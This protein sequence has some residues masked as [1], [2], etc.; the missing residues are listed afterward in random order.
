[1][2][3]FLSVAG[4]DRPKVEEVALALR[5]EGHEV[6]LDDHSLP[7]GSSYHRRIREAIRLADI[8]V[9]FVSTYS[10]EADRYTLS[11]L[12]FMQDKWPHPRGRILPTLIA[13][14]DFNKVPPYL[15][16]VTIY[17][18]QG[19]LAAEVADQVNRMSAELSRAKQ[20]KAA[21][22]GHGFL[23]GDGDPKFALGRAAVAALLLSLLAVVIGIL[24]DMLAP[25]LRTLNMPP[26]GYAVFHGFA[27]SLLA[28]I[29]AALFGVRNVLAFVMLT[30][31]SIAAFAFEIVAWS[32]MKDQL[33]VLQ[34]GKSTVFALF[35]AAALPGFRNVSRWAA[36]AAAGFLAGM[37]ATA[38]G[39]PVKIF[40]W[41]MLQVGALALFLALHESEAISAS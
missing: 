21:T 41:E 17:K 8:V 34:A 32:S 6:F 1:M 18:P 35:A 25:V 4:P 15:R 2:R 22:G 38:F 7:P 13:P 39:Y 28:W 27:F 36:L 20:R 23:S 16:A 24:T 31:G 5:D 10:L 12:K 37:L 40:V 19:N 11:E 33:P 14:V 29:V 26:L 30:L 9:F 3:V